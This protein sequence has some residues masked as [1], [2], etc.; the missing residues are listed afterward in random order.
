MDDL[1]EEV[2]PDELEAWLR[3]TE[4]IEEEDNRRT[5]SAPEATRSTSTKQRHFKRKTSLDYAASDDGRIFGIDA[6]TALRAAQLGSS[7]AQSSPASPKSSSPTDALLKPSSGKGATTSSSLPQT[8]RPFDR[9]HH[10]P[11]SFDSMYRPLTCAPIISAPT[12]FKEC[13]DDV[14]AFKKRARMSSFDDIDN[15]VTEGSQTP[16]APTSSE[17]HQTLSYPSVTAN[18]RRQ[19]CPSTSSRRSSLEFKTRWRNLLSRQ[20][21]QGPRRT[22]LPESMLSPAPTTGSIRQETPSSCPASFF[23]RMEKQSFQFY[24]VMSSGCSSNNVEQDGHHDDNAMMMDVSETSNV[25]NSSSYY[26]ELQAAMEQTHQ[27]RRMIMNTLLDGSGKEGIDINNGHAVAS[28]VAEIANKMLEEELGVQQCG[29][30]G[31]GGLPPPPPSM[32]TTTIMAA[33]QRRK[34]AAE[35]AEAKRSLERIRREQMILEKRLTELQLQR[36]SGR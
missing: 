23:H 2:T 20:Q 33:A 30:V 32:T 11:A 21:G 16:L 22:S 17:D 10:Q 25:S 31:E 7:P 13:N 15:N 1:S 12:N 36:G 28:G 9:S 27:S 19:S 3:T 26:D 24:R 6:Q 14:G 34:K 35:E 29:V 8:H 4:V 18:R 5:Q